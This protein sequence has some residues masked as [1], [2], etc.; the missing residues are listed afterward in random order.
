MSA[1]VL[2]VGLRYAAPSAGLDP[3][4]VCASAAAAV[5]DCR[6]HRWMCWVDGHLSVDGSNTASCGK[7]TRWPLPTDPVEA[8]AE[9]CKRCHRAQATLLDA[10]AWQAFRRMKDAAAA[11]PEPW[12]LA[13]GNLGD[14]ESWVRHKPPAEWWAQAGP[15]LLRLLGL[16]RP[17]ANEPDTEAVS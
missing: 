8:P 5:A 9:P 15:A 3:D 7:V 17:P 12:V 16:E 10:A 6:H 4:T 13:E 14:P 2:P 1:Y 11:Q